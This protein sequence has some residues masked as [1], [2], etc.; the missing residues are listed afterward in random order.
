MSLDSWRT[1]MKSMSAGLENDVEPSESDDDAEVLSEQDVDSDAE[2]MFKVRAL[3][4]AMRSW[5][6]DEDLEADR[7]HRLADELRAHPHLPADP[8]DPDA[9][10]PFKDLD[11]IDDYVRLP[12]AH[13]PFKKCHWVQLHGQSLSGVSRAPE[14]YLLRHLRT[15]H[16]HLF[17][18]I[19]G[20]ACVGPASRP[21]SVIGIPGTPYIV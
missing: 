14:A 20:E 10:A 16:K 15:E 12:Y 5:Q 7:I 11:L 8:S 3:P 19:C 17:K 13:C 2:D 21:K 9:T 6:T 4:R 18:T 1:L